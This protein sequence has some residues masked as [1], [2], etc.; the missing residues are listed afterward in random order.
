MP[1]WVNWVLPLAMLASYALLVLVLM[2]RL[3]AEAGGAMPF[4]LRVFG[5]SRADAHAY[6][7][8]LSPA[9]ARLYL[10][11]VRLADTLFPILL[12]LTL[13][14][15][16]YRWRAWWALPALAYGISDLAEN[17]AVARLVRTGP[18]VDSGS[19]VLASALTEAK[20]ALVAVA[21]MLAAAALV[22]LALARRR[23]GR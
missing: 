10:G 18:A 1:R 20:F 6:L 2:P 8:A 11:P 14:L 9:G 4:D 22:S 12:S 17:W 23:R 13:C 7:Q 3:V 15:P 21:L 16:L 5:Y 19:V